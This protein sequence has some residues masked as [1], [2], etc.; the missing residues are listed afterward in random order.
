MN[1]VKETSFQIE[2]LVKACLIKDRKAQIKLYELYAK[3]MYN[4]SLRIV[5]DTML[6]EDV[7][8]E[9]FLKAFTSLAGFRNEVPFIAWLKRIV[10]NKSL[11]EL[12]KRKEFL[13]ID[14]NILPEIPINNGDILELEYNERSV[15]KVKQAMNE[16]SD[17]YRVI[18]SL[19]YFEGY[20]HDEIAQVLH[21]TSSTS[22]SQL[23]RAK[24]KIINKLN[25]TDS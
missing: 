13:P 6:A 12:R 4:V 16:L 11:D 5:Q 9:S 3:K 19:F 22:R 14:E 7:V 8:Q 23:T 25:N 24:K 17:G 20:D 15:Q 2:E 10:I 1:R 21:I 18:F